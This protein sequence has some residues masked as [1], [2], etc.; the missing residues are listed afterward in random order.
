ML[1]GRAL[2]RVLVQ[3][4]QPWGGGHVEAAQG[5]DAGVVVD[6]D[7][8]LPE[9]ACDVPVWFPWVGVSDGTSGRGVSTGGVL[10]TGGVCRGAVSVAVQRSWT[11]SSGGTS[12]R[13]NSPTGSSRRGPLPD[14]RAPSTESVVEAFQDRLKLGG[15]AAQRAQPHPWLLGWVQRPVQRYPDAPPAPLRSRRRARHPPFGLPSLKR[16]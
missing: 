15:G 16:R 1:A 2:L 6:D 3:L 13:W 10:R 7:P 12:E 9:P 8:G 5:G 4:P 14:P 11:G